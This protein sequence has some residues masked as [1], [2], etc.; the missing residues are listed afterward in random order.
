MRY[1][2]KMPGLQLELPALLA[3]LASAGM[4]FAC[5]ARWPGNPMND[6][7]YSIFA[8]QNLLAHGQLK[9]L[10]VLADYHDDVA[11]FAHL[12]WMVHFPPG[13]SLLYAAAMGLGLNAGSATK[14]LALVGILA[15][16]LGW[17]FL[18]RFLGASR[19]CI[20][21]LAAIYPWLPW[22]GSAYQ[23]Y[24]T[25]HVAFALMPWFCLALLR[26]APIAIPVPA[27]SQEPVPDRGR[28]LLV[29]IL[30]AL[31]L[32]TLKYSMSPVFL[33]AA[34]YLLLLDGFRFAGRSIWWKAAVLGLLVFP[35]LLS[36]L[37]NYAYGPRVT[38]AG[39]QTPYFA[40]RFARNILD[41]SV[42]GTF[43]WDKPIAFLSNLAHLRPV[44]GLVDIVSLASLAIWIAHFWRHPPQGRMRAFVH[45]LVLLTI[46]LWLS[47]VASTYLAKQWDFSAA[48]RL[49]MPIT[50]LWVLCCALSLDAMRAREMFRSPALYTL[51]FPI[52]L[53]AVIAIKFAVP[54]PSYPAMPQ[55][56]IAWTASRDA[57]HAAFLSRL[58]AS[59]GRSPDVLIGTPSVMNELAVPSISNGYLVPPGHHYWSSTKLELWALIL[60][61]QE[62][63][64][65]ADFDGAGV[66]RVATPP[67][68]P[69]LLYV[70]KLGPKPNR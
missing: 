55:S 33:A 25:E 4:Q 34:L 46:A 65:L 52:L 37:V 2:V 31:V 21:L 36:Q 69:F 54:H 16:G 19:K 14:A 44:E 49:Y 3:L 27:Q 61:S 45:L 17:I 56:G 39:A 5:F 63:A 40:F 22:G 20:A 41:I 8:A 30:L 70:F 26:I 48:D 38:Q 59:R 12:R 29:V 47:L 10:N 67:G 18:G 50:L 13:H 15:G 28:Q 57:E 51:A 43:G 60:P 42:S 24:E 32:I 11:Q 66:Q 7:S 58:A 68:F 35:L 64:L 9:S 6:V 23:L 53:T 62:K 1:A